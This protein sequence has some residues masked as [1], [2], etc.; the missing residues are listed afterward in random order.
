MLNV[1]TNQVVD[2]TVVSVCE[3][4]TQMTWRRREYNTLNSVKEVGV[5]VAGVSTDSYPQIK[6][7]T[8]EEQKDKKHHIDP[9]HALK[10]VCKKLRESS[11]KRGCEKLSLWI[12]SITNH[13]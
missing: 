13:L 2:F 12:P 5:W 9:W 8:R 11:K 10:N 6:K 1:S 4:K 3:V 7:Y